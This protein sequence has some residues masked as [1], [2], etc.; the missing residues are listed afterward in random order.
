V[1]DLLRDQP[2][3]WLAAEVSSEA[4]A[5]SLLAALEVLRPG[6]R[7]AHPFIEEFRMARAID[8]YEGLIETVL[9]GT[10]IDTPSLDLNIQ[11]R[12]P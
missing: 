1:C 11:E 5:A 6:D 3:A 9:I 2:G 4:L 7:F 12:Q 8:A 10:R